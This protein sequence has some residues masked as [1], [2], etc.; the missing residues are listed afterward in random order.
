MAIFSSIKKS[1]V[2]MESGSSNA[3][4]LVTSLSVPCAFF[5]ATERGL[6]GHVTR[7]SGMIPGLLNLFTMGG[8]HETK[9]F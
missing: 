8:C 7:G 4:G 2:R 1:N 6:R 9:R 3:R 5:V